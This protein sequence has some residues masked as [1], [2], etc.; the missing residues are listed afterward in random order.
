VRHIPKDSDPQAGNRVY[1]RSLK[2]P[3]GH[4]PSSGRTGD[5]PAGSVNPAETRA[6]ALSRRRFLNLVSASA[7]LALGTSSCSKIDRG[8]IVPYTRKPEE[9]VPGVAT[10]YAST[11]QEGVVTEGVLVKT[12]EGRPILVEG[13][14]EHTITRGK[15][16][17]RAMADVLG[18][19]DPDRLRRP[20]AAGDASTWEKAEQEIAQAL[21]AVR[22]A[23]AP[24]LLLTEALISPTR[25]A[26]IE[27]LR[28]ALPALR[29]AAW[30]PAAPQAA[31]LASRALYGEFLLPRLRFD[32]AE[33]ILSLQDDFLGINGNAPAFI[34]DFSARRAI[35]S[36]SDPMN[37]LWV[38]EGCMTLT[39]ANA[40]QRLQ[41]RPS[42][43]APLGFALARTLNEVHGV[44]LPRDLNPD[45]LKSFDL[46]ALAN[47]LAIK[48]G[49]LPA[50]A[51]DLRRAGRS[52]LVLAGAALPPEAHVACHL[53]NGMLGAEGHTVDTDFAVPGP[54]LLTFDGLRELLDEA[55]RGTFPVAIFW[56]TNPAY[57][58]PDA[59]AWKSAV[60]NIPL[61]I[62]VGL[63][64]DETALACRWR[65]PEHHWL[66]AWGDF[67]PAAD[68]L[69]LRQPTMG[70]IH[71]TRQGEH[72]LL[73][74]L[75]ALGKDV[76][77]NY[78]EYL[79][80]RWQREV[81]PAGSPV[82][83]ELFWNAALH[84]GV[85]K[86]EPRPRPARVARTGAFLEAMSAASASR[87][88]G[89]GDALELVLLPGAAAYDGRYANNGW[90]NELPD[91]VTKGTW[92][93]PL[94]VS[95]SD[96]ERL[97]LEDGD[98]VTVSSGAAGLEVPVIIQPG[99][100]P[101]VAGLALGLGRSTGNVATGVGVNAFPLVDLASTCPNLRSS[102]KIV[103]RG[104][105]RA[106]PRTQ[107][108][109]R[110][111]DRDPA[112][113]W[114]LREYAREAETGEAEKHGH[115]VVSLIPPQKFIGHKWGMV[116]DLSACVGCSACVIACQA[117]NNIPVVGP[118][119]VLVG[120]Q[121]QWI[122]IDRYYQGDPSDPSVVHQPLLCQHCDDA[123]CEIVCPVNA[124]THSPDGLNQMAYNRCVG[125]RY[126]S[127]N[128]PFKVRRFNFFDYTSMKKEPASLVFNPEVTVR[129]RGVMEKCSFCI[130][131]I[132]DVRQRANVEGR[133]VRD[134]EIRP[135][136]AV[137]CPAEAILFG[138]VND[139]ESR[140]S[141]MAKIDRGYRML[142]E[143]AV[144]PSI[145]YL[146][147]I[148]NPLIG[149]GK[150]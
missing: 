23:G 52:A 78:L 61:K 71:D 67:E 41:V 95:L 132:Q 80:A 42:Q 36:P 128:C 44:P 49:A 9:V 33:V 75:R 85:L 87:S 79:R 121:M 142:E 16:S 89:A 133:P 25:R 111:E 134:G 118:E 146:A 76:S 74:C 70:A 110:M 6:D 72:I 126:C 26:L 32:R 82:S 101:G 27:E 137:A 90:L 14:A 120:R 91:P 47:Q 98:L 59:A 19:Y 94:L 69:S 64:E 39:G 115:E 119:R 13:N 77:S 144:K 150:A 96:A 22:D 3:D 29:H 105:R 130:Q 50:L 149:K 117:E 28:A 57:S 136:C 51:G 55:G 114:T 124:T 122:R 108:H 127:N 18:L 4:A 54:E 131:R 102:V 1:F 88:A 30:E 62:R 92:G 48:P 21:R 123:P 100:A 141:R 107:E 140:V 2:G 68:L 81:Y 147:D 145:T 103:R 97:E 113:S 125:T 129:P 53:L 58:C 46:E 12:R 112:R 65:L 148:S 104:G 86:R 24:V 10:Y 93:N 20:S 43:I 17:L 7:A 40:D 84:D 35:S 66:E 83:F 34:R 38:I 116:I 109:S 135:A 99:Q 106:I 56:G 73:T 45:S 143:L 63:Y 15:I 139:P 31:I 138:D 37:R 60:A 11:F 5:F 8:K